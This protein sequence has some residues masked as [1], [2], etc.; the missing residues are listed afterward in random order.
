MTDAEALEILV[1]ALLYHIYKDGDDELLVEVLR[2]LADV[3]KMDP[4]LL[5]NTLDE[6]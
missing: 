3:C 6:I 5:H 1:D 4:S 2:D